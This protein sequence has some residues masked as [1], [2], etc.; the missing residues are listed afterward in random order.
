MNGDFGLLMQETTVKNHDKIPIVGKL[1]V[2]I[3]RNQIMAQL[4]I[5][6]G[7]NFRKNTA[8]NKTVAW[9]H[10]AHRTEH[11]YFNSTEQYEVY[12]NNMNN[13]R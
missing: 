12:W 2:S 6:H 9:T 10:K 7:L 11:Y 1:L 4:K 5:F 3:S 8:T 13:D